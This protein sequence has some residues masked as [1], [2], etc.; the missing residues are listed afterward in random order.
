MT[1][2]NHF[3][4]SA[5][6]R[7]RRSASKP[8]ALELWLTAVAARSGAEA[9]VLADGDGFL[10][11]GSA[12]GEQAEEL[13]ALA[14]LV[15]ADGNVQIGDLEPRPLTVRPIEFEGEELYHCAAAARNPSQVDAVEASAAVN[16]ILAA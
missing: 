16:R 7:R 5:D 13:A 15:H 14:P 4:F 9:V 3:P 10:V 6:R 2:V 1:Y 8:E 12:D 11:A